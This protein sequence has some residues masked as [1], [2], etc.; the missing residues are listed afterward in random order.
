M[1]IDTLPSEGFEGYKRK[2]DISI[3]NVCPSVS[4]LQQT[5]ITLYSLLHSSR[6]PESQICFLYCDIEGR[7][8]NDLLHHVK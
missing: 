2:S 4:G 7:T 8:H 3:T 1:F 5:N 6:I